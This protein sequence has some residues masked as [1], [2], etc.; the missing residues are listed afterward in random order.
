MRSRLGSACLLFCAIELIVFHTGIYKSIMEPGSSAGFLKSILQNE[1]RR[2]ITN[3]NQV[4][5]IGDSR[6]ALRP[7]IADERL[8]ETGYTF[9][10]IAV[11]GTTPRCWYYMLR[12]VDPHRN[13]YAAIVLPTNEYEDDDWENL[14]DRT[15]DIYY[16]IP[17]L[18]V[19]DVYDFTMSFPEW[20]TRWEA[21]RGSLLK[22]WTYRKDFQELLTDPSKRMFAVRWARD[23]QA[24]SLYNYAWPTTNVNGLSVDFSKKTIEYP[25]GS[26]ADQ[27][28]VF[29]EVLL[30]GYN[31]AMGLR[32]AYREKWFGRI[33]DYYRGSRTKLIFIRMPRGPLVRPAS[34]YPLTSS[35]RDFGRRGEAIVSD[36]HYFDDLEHTQFFIDPVHLNGPGAERFTILLGRLVRSIL[37]PPQP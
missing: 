30:R 24:R 20:K 31:P 28:R 29:R 13:R 14:A 16:L 35:I 6:M 9:T 37:G 8:P 18:R 32:K 17:L 1:M 33:F 10:N 23:E 19:G 21:F 27:E 25:P 3:S 36:E 15:L 12:E 7:K 4:A 2:P 5:A 26:T 22:G 11:P 34:P